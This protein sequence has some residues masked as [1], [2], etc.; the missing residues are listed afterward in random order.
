VLGKA[1]SLIARNGS[2]I[3]SVAD[4]KGKTVGVPMGSTA[5]YSLMGALEHEGLSET[6]VNIVGMKP[7]LGAGHHRRGLGLA[8]GAVRDPEN[9]HPD[10]RCR[11]DRRMGLSDL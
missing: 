4:L 11:P 2:N 10:H 6:D 8:A 9:R 5:H 1:E 7:D 3:A